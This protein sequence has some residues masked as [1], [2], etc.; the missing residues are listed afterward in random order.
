MNERTNSSPAGGTSIWRNVLIIRHGATALNS[1]DHSKDRIR[2]WSDWPLSKQG[3][4]EARLLAMQINKAPS[5][6]LCSNLT[7][8]EQ[9]ASIIADEFNIPYHMSAAFLPWD[10][11]LF[12]G[13]NAAEAMPKLARYA[14]D[15]HKIVPG[16]ESFDTF[17][18]RFLRGLLNVLKHDNGLIGI[19]T[20]HRCERLLKAWAKAE[21]PE[22]GD[23]DLDEF[24]KKGEPTGHCE[25]VKVPMHRLQLWK[26]HN[27]IHGVHPDLQPRPHAASG[28]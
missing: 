5:T 9:T 12:V 11:G 19:V 17:R 16:G 21:Y 15:S 22:N 4:G 23:V 13:A 24:I 2:G 26:Q 25:I 1:D 14:V 10:V 8:A 27:E 3:A 7:R 18:T 28:L 6:L 20:H